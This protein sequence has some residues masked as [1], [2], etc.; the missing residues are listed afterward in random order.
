[1]D[2]ERKKYSEKVLKRYCVVCVFQFLSGISRSYK[3]V[4]FN[5]WKTLILRDKWSKDDTY[6]RIDHNIKYIS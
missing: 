4:I 3:F 1:V 6:T 2:I 5:Y